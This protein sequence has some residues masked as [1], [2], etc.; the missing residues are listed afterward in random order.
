MNVGSILTPWLTLAAVF[1]PLVFIER[2][3]HSHLYGV[4][5][6]ISRGNPRTATVLYYIILFPGVFVHEFTQYLIAGALNVRIKKVVAWPEAQNDGT[7]RLDFVRIQ[8]ARWYQAAI[9]GAAPLVVGTTLVWLISNHVLKLTELLDAIGTGDI[10]VIGTAVQHLASTPDFYIWLYLVF[11]ISNAMFPTPADRQGWPLLFG[12]FVA[13]IVLL[14]VLGVQPDVLLSWYEA[15]IAAGLEIMATAFAAVLVVALLNVLLIGFLEEV[16]ERVTGRKFDYGRSR[17]RAGAPPRAQYRGRE[18]GAAAP[19][20]FD[21]PLPSIYNQV[22]PVP[23]P[24]KRSLLPARKSALA[25]SK[26]KPAVGAPSSRQPS[27]TLERAQS[28]AAL[29]EARPATDTHQPRPASVSMDRPTAESPLPRRDAQ[30]AI[31]PTREGIAATASPR[32]PARP[33]GPAPTTPGDSMTSERRVSPSGRNFQ[34]PGSK[35]APGTQ[36]PERRLSSPFAALDDED[37]ITDEEMEEIEELED[38][39]DVGGDDEIDDRTDIS[40]DNEEDD[41]IQLVP[42]D[43]I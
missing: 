35:G 12:G 4:G 15:N 22:L 40:D 1:V 42:F 37:V 23:D 29:P 43:D 27:P 5:W 36:P 7:L 14:L 30:P 41:D 16:L 11:A 26:A 8:K 24:A 19:L 9:I 20:P 18:P 17:P 6:L 38:I 33:Y 34:P 2:W 10:T 13:L 39:D 25:A 31:S 21:V 28:A 3:L 32:P